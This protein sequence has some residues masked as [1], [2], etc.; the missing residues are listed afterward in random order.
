MCKVSQS[1]IV[2]LFYV[3]LA[4]SIALPVK[5]QTYSDAYR[6]YKAKNYVQAAGMLES[7]AQAGDASAQGLLG[8]MY[9]KGLG[10]TRDLSKARALTLQS[11]EQGNKV[12][13]QNLAAMFLQGKGGPK[14]YRVSFELAQKCEARP[15][16][17]DILAVLYTKGWGVP[18]DL[19]KALEYTVA[20][21]ESTEAPESF[22]GRALFRLSKYY[23]KG[24]AGVTKDLE[25]AFDLLERA[26]SKGHRMAVA[27]IGQSYE[28]GIGTERN[29][30]KALE[31]YNEF[32]RRS[33]TYLRRRP[34]DQNR[35]EPQIDMARRKINALC[36][37]DNLTGCP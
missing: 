36:T 18:K 2:M 13:I 9:L 37:L 15:K 24:L 3:L 23:R 25:Q 11:A 30:Q 10:V 7:L 17:K 26:K 6:E 1:H 27:Q 4:T 19:K 31:N 21:A 22:R 16:C 12:S 14:N 8:L 32:I 5:A 28:D 34:N 29:K 35:V 20:V 33:E